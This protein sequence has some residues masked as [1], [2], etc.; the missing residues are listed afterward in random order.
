MPIVPLAPSKR[1]RKQAFGSEPKM[2]N[3]V[4]VFGMQTGLEGLSVATLRTPS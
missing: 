4:T 2:G 1:T 3:R